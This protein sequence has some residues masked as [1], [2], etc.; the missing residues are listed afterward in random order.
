MGFF[1]LGGGDLS[2]VNITHKAA[3]L[4]IQRISRNEPG[5]YRR[6]RKRSEDLGLRSEKS[7]PSITSMLLESFSV[8][9]IFFH[10]Y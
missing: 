7:F 6:R 10:V 5:V 9:D 1:C 2:V 3:Q 4:I 8:E